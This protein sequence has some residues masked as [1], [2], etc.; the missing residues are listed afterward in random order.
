MILTR[1][2]DF[3][4]TLETY[5]HI[6]VHMYADIAQYDVYLLNSCGHI[7]PLGTRRDTRSA[8]S[9]L[10]RYKSF[11]KNSSFKATQR[12]TDVEVSRRSAAMLLSVRP[13]G[14]GTMLSQTRDEVGRS[15]VLPSPLII[16]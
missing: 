8:G 1:N 13:R 9:I 15:T 5:V 16:L 11:P 10:R 2:R 4:N 14:P 7:F 3:K 6:Y 12:D